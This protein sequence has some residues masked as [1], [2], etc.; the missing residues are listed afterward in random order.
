MNRNAGVK[1]R[2]S[3]DGVLFQ[4]YNATLGRKF[5][6]GNSCLICGKDDVVSGGEKEF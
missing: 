1:F 5:H 3:T 6:A 4:L 2:S